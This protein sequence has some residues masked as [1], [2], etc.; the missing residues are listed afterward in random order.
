MKSF[1]CA[2]H[3]IYSKS[4]YKR[5]GYCLLFSIICPITFC[6]CHGLP[7]VGGCTLIEKCSP[8]T[9][10]QTVILTCALRNVIHWYFYRWEQLAWLM[11]LLLVILLKIPRKGTESSKQ[12]ICSTPTSALHW[13]RTL[14]EFFLDNE[15][16]LI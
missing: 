3:I 10:P 5:S 14:C 11:I 9:M 13:V 4:N 15:I 16:G 7:R 6:H 2:N 12:N 1:P 8:C